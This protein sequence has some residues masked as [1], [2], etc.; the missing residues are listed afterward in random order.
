M[1]LTFISIDLDLMFLYVLDTKQM[2][3]CEVSIYVHFTTSVCVSMET[4]NPCKIGYMQ[5]VSYDE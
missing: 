4:Q 1:S 5:N 2:V 3:H